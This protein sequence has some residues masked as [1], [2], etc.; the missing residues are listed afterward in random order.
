MCD[1]IIGHVD[2]SVTDEVFLLQKLKS[3]NFLVFHFTLQYEKEGDAFTRRVDTIFLV[4]LLLALGRHTQYCM[5][6]DGCRMKNKWC[7]RSKTDGVT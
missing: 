4:L 5:V 7:S 6:Y 3:R 1:P 2:V